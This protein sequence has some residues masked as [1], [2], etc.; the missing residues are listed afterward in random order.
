MT[1]ADISRAA[2]GVTNATV[3]TN[4]TL[5]QQY[6]QRSLLNDTKNKVTSQR[7]TTNRNKNNNRNKDNRNKGYNNNNNYNSNN[8]MLIITVGITTIEIRIIVGIRLT[9][10]IG[11]TISIIEIRVN[12][13]ISTEKE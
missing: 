1:G 9:A 7:M 6:G 12:R 11:I 10:E 5:V 4:A 2:K 3:V 13:I 8:N